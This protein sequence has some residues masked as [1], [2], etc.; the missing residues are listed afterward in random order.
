LERRGTDA[1][2]SEKPGQVLVVVDPADS[3]GGE[4]RLSIFKEKEKA[5]W[6]HLN[7]KAREKRA[8]SPRNLRVYS[9]RTIKPPKKHRDKIK[10]GLHVGT[11]PI[12]TA[13]QTLD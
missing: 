13:N 9:P 7:R 12:I 1:G 3:K 6:D 10:E 8:R 11:T 2:A 5:G 4:G